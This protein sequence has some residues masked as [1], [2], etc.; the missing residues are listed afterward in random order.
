METG[1]KYKV[2]KNKKQYFNYCKS[3]E[4]L[5]VAKS[6]TVNDK[7]EIALLTLLIEIWDTAHDT[8]KKLEP[9]ELIKALMVEHGLRSKEMIKIMGVS[10]GMVS[11][12]LNRRKGLSK[13]VIRDLAAYFKMDQAAFNRPYKLV[14]EVN[15]KYRYA[16]LMNTRK[17]LTSKRT[18]VA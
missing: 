12:I 16:N 6:N 18:S 3:L 7:D 2:I 15:K 9:V 13:A 17:D 10:K 14:A 8:F 4:A 5:L 1:L 11:Q